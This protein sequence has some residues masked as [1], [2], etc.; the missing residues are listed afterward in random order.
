MTLDALFLISLR[1]I[2]LHTHHVIIIKIVVGIYH[3]SIIVRMQTG[4]QWG[5]TLKFRTRNKRGL[6]LWNHKEHNNVFLCWLMWL[7][8]THSQVHSF[9]KDVMTTY[10][11]V[12]SFDLCLWSERPTHP[13]FH[14]EVYLFRLTYSVSP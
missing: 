8:D 9:V 2:S 11:R 13:L 5:G 10:Q 7:C 4:S 6:L 3:S 12:K 14:I 1:W